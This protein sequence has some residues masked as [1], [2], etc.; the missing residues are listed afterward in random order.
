MAEDLAVACPAFSVPPDELIESPF[1]AREV[2]C[3]SP[4]QTRAV[5]SSA[6]PRR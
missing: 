6:W 5:T 3:E 4:V 2:M 1:L